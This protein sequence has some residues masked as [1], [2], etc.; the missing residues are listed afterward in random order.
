[1]SLEDVPTTLPPLRPLLIERTP[2]SFAGGHLGG[3]K[4]I[5]P[6]A[7]RR[8]AEVIAAI[9]LD[10]CRDA[11]P[12]DLGRVEVA[13]TGGEG[14]DAFL[15]EAELGLCQYC[16]CGWMVRGRRVV[17]RPCVPRGGDEGK[18]ETH[19]CIR[20]YGLADARLLGLGEGAVTPAE[21]GNG[22]LEAA[23]LFDLAVAHA[24]L[25]VVDEELVLIGPA[26][27]SGGSRCRR[28]FWRCCG[29][30]RRGWRRRWRRESKAWSRSC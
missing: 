19:I 29:R 24:G 11:H 5:P 17:L 7:T 22:F 21:G 26:S 28:R 8:V 14:A 3:H 13:G 30:C 9:I 18:G 2:R 10:V 1:M 25:P 15:E 23:Q 6:L 20:P 27:S 4:L 16:H 12:G